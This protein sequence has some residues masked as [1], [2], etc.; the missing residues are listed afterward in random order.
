MSR[1]PLRESLKAP[2]VGVQPSANGTPDRVYYS[3]GLTIQPQQFESVRFDIGHATDVR[4]DETPESALVR[5][6]ALIHDAAAQQAQQIR[7]MRETGV[8]EPVRDKPKG[9]SKKHR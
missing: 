5:I 8:P 3:F 7:G 2:K 4:A 1:K 6:A 9:K